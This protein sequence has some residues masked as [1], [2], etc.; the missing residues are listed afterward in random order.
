MQLCISADLEGVACVSHAA[1]VSQADSGAYAAACA[2]MTAEVAAAC[3][4]GFAAG[5]T[6]ILVKDAHWTGRNLDVQRM[7]APA[8]RSSV[9]T[10]PPAGPVTRW[11]TRRPAGCS[12]R[13]R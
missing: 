12:R 2:R 11:P 13:S 5:A 7:T 4:G 9:I 1:E 6:E 3:D 8:S 10:R